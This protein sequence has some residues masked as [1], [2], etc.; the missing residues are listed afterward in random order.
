[1]HPIAD[2]LCEVVRVKDDRVFVLSE[3]LELA[4]TL[5]PDA[6]RADRNV[7]RDL[8]FVWS[9]FAEREYQPATAQVLALLRILPLIEEEAAALQSEQKARAITRIDIVKVKRP[10]GLGGKVTLGTVGMRRQ[11]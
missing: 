5:L 7:F 1:M 3:F 9:T 8:L 6:Y 4:R 10:D 2:K 11:V